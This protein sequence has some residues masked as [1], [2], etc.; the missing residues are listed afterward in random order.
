MGPGTSR[1][2]LSRSSP[3]RDGS[4]T[5]PLQ[6]MTP[7]MR[8]GER[9]PS[10]ARRTRVFNFLLDPHLLAETNG[11]LWPRGS[12]GKFVTVYPRSDNHFRRLGERLAKE[13]RDFSGPYILS[14]R[15]WPGSKCVFYRYGGFRARSVLQIDGTR[16]FVIASPAGELVPDLRY[17]YWSPPE[18]VDDPLG[19]TEHAVESQITLANGRFSITTALRFTN[20]GG[21][22][23]AVDMQ[24]DQEVVIKESRPMIEVGRHR[25]DSIALLEKEWRLLNRLADTG[26][27]VKPIAFFSRGRARLSG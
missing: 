5:L 16:A 1:V 14:D 9:S 18:W 25:V 26:Y 21:V 11:K 20:R 15:R 27:F 13:L 3:I 22:Y 6:R 24:S 12:S 2:L 7:S 8:C 19:G 17:P 23:R 4:S 10:F